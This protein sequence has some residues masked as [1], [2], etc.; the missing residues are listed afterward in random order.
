[1]GDIEVDKI[2][3]DSIRHFHEVLRKLPSS[4]NK[5]VAYRGKTLEEILSMDVPCRFSNYPGEEGLSIF[6]ID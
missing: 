4:I 2:D 1:M 5:R 6:G 3:R